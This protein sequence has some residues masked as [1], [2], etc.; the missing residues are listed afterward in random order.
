MRW[1]WISTGGGDG[2]YSTITV[3]Y[4]WLPTV[5]WRGVRKTV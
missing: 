3:S 1:V 2:G 4:A 5:S